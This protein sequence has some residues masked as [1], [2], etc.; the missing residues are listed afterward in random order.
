MLRN[1]LTKPIAG[2]LKLNK[3]KYIIIGAGP[4]GL[5]TAYFL[6]KIGEDYMILESAEKSGSFFE[7]FPIHRKLIS[8][9]KKYTGSNNPEFNLRHDWNSLL[10]EGQEIKLS[11]YDDDLYPSADNLVTY[12]NDYQKKYGLKVEFGQK[13]TSIKKNSLFTIETSQGEQWKCEVCIYAGGFTRANL[14]SDI[15]GIEYATDYADIDTDKS[16]YNNQ[17]VLIIGKGNSAFETADHLAGNAALIHVVGPEK[18]QFAWETHYVGHLRA[19]NNNILDMYQLKSQHAVLDAKI[20]SIKYQDGQYAVTLNY[21][22]AHEEVETI[23]YDKILSCAGFKMADNIWK[24]GCEIETEFSGKFPRLKRNFESSNIDNFYFVGVLTHVLDYRKATS[25]FIHGFRYNCRALINMLAMKTNTQKWPG[26]QLTHSA[27][28]YTAKI[29]ERVNSASSLWQQPGYFAD[30]ILVPKAN[31]L[32]DIP[33]DGVFQGS[34][35]F[36]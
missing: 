6:D 24:D 26:S 12:L 3:H 15:E 27:A 10:T 20:N 36:L 11:D 22:H 28:E 19:V 17:R 16:K 25:G 21:A 34:C 32:T 8:I 18:L 7:N 30:V 31:Y 35:R 9:N 33:A 2:K 14:P 13:V 5:Q 29:I 1:F 4:S 23:I